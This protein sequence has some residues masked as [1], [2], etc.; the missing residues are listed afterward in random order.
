MGAV[1]SGLELT[2]TGATLYYGTDEN[3]ITRRADA[4]GRTVKKYPI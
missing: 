4:E 3:A 2:S 1:N